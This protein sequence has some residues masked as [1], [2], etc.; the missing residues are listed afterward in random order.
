MAR[1]WAEYWKEFLIVAGA[2]LFA[3]MSPGPDLA[4]MIKTSLTA[5]RKNAVATAIGIGLGIGIHASYCL[6]GI[7]VILQN[8]PRLF[9]GIKYLGAI[10]LGFL[11]VKCLRAL[12]QKYKLETAKI[13]SEKGKSA[14]ALKSFAVGFIT[15]VLNP[16]A[17]LFFLSLFS[18]V[19]NPETPLP[20]QIVYGV[21]M[22]IATAAWFSAVGIFLTH[23][24]FK[25]KFEA[26]QS[27]LIPTM[28][29]VLIA[30]AIR[31]I[32]K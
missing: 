2:H 14:G 9:N 11:G 5:V 1:L 16:K 13:K 26:F 20:I 6:L 19:I 17:T 15:N 27:V 18:Q 23:P 10:Y 25:Q 21:E 32:W 31:I 8:S 29:F 12:G 30:L 7:A 22:M 3:V 4:V 24:R 28:G